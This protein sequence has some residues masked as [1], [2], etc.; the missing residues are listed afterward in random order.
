MK[1]FITGGTGFIGK[2]LVPLLRARGHNVL[3][4]VRRYLEQNRGHSHVIFGDLEQPI[5]YRGALESFAPDCSIHLGWHGLPDYSYDNCRD[6]LLAGLN[7][8]EIL[9]SIGCSK[10]VALGTC[11]EYGGLTGQLKETHNGVALNLFAA[12][13]LALKEIGESYF[14]S[15]STK[16]IWVRPFFVYGPDQR[17]SSLIPLTFR[18]L[19][20]KEKLSIQNPLALNDFINVY[21]VASAIVTLVESTQANGTYN[22]GTGKPHTVWEVVNFISS[23][24]GQKDVYECVTNPRMDAFWA[25]TKKMNDLGW[26]PQL[27]LEEGI[28]KTIETWLK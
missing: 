25:D 1:I 2:C 24:L 14:S 20:M 4:L 10:L 6:N 5:T 19:L 23:A 21:D 27:S 18:S 17:T 9:Q 28:S 13:K 26:E 7:L 8:Y 22:V 12:Y 3:L 15:S 11:W 16:F